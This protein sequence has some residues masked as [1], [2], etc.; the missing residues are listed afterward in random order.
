MICIFYSDLMVDNWTCHFKRKSVILGVFFKNSQ[1]YH[2]N[3]FFLTWWYADGYWFT[4]IKESA[5]LLSLLLIDCLNHNGLGLNW[6]FLSIKGDA[7]CYSIKH[8]QIFT[9]ITGIAIR[10]S[11]KKPNVLIIKC[12]I[13]KNF[14]PIRDA[15]IV[16]CLDRWIERKK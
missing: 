6:K 1:S 10:V 8:N 4:K 12:L 13:G 16:S 11:D 9:G 2:S 7:C 15:A 14:L 3:Q 5:C